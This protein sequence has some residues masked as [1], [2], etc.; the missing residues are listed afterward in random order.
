[1]SQVKVSVGADQIKV[2]ARTVVEPEYADYIGPLVVTP[3][4]ETQTLET[5]GHLLR[6]NI[7]VEP[8][9]NY[10]GLI[11]WNGQYLTVS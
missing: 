8:I 5:A 1:M 6:G 10:Y 11:T 7:T 4:Q 2:S 9:P 3:S